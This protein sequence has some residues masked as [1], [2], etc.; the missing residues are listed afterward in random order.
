MPC[1]AGGEEGAF[2]TIPIEDLLSE[3]FDRTRHHISGLYHPWQALSRKW[4]YGLVFWLG[5][6]LILAGFGF[7]EFQIDLDCKAFTRT[8]LLL[9]DV[10][11]R[12][13]LHSWA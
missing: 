6:L 12:G 11:F 2:K 4:L 5:C 8:A 10:D 7:I 3:E 1:R 9:I 13:G